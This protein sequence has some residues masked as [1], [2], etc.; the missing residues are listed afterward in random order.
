MI[1]AF[2]FLIKFVHGILVKGRIVKDGIKSIWHG[3]YG[4]F[5]KTNESWELN[6]ELILLHTRKK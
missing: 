6:E 3:I 1:A 5:K 4:M 2:L